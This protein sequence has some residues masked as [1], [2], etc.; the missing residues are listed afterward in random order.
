MAW[1]WLPLIFGEVG[2]SPLLITA[3][4]AQWFTRNVMCQ[5]V[6]RHFLKHLWIM[7]HI[8]TNRKAK[9]VFE[10]WNYSIYQYKCRG[11]V[12]IRVWVVWVVWVQYHQ[13]SHPSL[14][15][16]LPY[17]VTLGNIGE[18]IFWTVTSPVSFFVQNVFCPC[19]RR[20]PPLEGGQSLPRVGMLDM[21]VVRGWGV[22]AALWTDMVRAAAWR[23]RSVL[24]HLCLWWAFMLFS[25]WTAWCRTS[26]SLLSS[27][28]T[29]LVLVIS[30]TSGRRPFMK[31]SLRWASQVETVLPKSA[32]CSKPLWRLKNVS[33]ASEVF[34][35]RLIIRLSAGGY[36]S[37]VHA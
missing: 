7:F 24:S 36:F 12:C 33:E 20:F 28:P 3:C 15:Q 9:F 35:D 22:E 32:G 31:L 13:S 10:I 17:S 5:I 27:Q 25:A 19:P 4:V 26:P 11:C 6:L 8:S 37:W 34:R 29:Q 30:W 16:P 21:V 23:S 1:T 18:L 2:N 14:P